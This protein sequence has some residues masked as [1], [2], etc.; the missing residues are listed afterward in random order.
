[1]KLHEGIK[2]YQNKLIRLIKVFIIILLSGLS[3]THLFFLPGSS[4]QL[5]ASCINTCNV[6]LWTDL[7]PAIVVCHCP[8]ELKRLNI[9]LVILLGRFHSKW[10]YLCRVFCKNVYYWLGPPASRRL[11]RR[12]ITTGYAV[13][14]RTFIADRDVESILLRSQQCLVFGRQLSGM[15]RRCLELIA[16]KI[17]C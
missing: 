12:R 14:Q 10:I 13:L 7:M 11:L 15:S 3:F 16:L 4:F 6:L 17:R 8:A 2:Q 5:V 9:V 1:M